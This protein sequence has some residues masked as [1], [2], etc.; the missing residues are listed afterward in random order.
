MIDLTEPWRIDIEH[1]DCVAA[2]RADKSDT[3]ICQ[4]SPSDDWEACAHLIAMAPALLAK[5]KN[6]V[7]W[8][9]RL[10]D[11]SRRQARDTRF[12]TMRE[13]CEAD[14]KNYKATADDIEKTIAQTVPEKKQ[15]KK[16]ARRTASDSL[17]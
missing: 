8:L 1:P 2:I 13:A 11:Q 3:E 4:I 16:R 14:A 9:R 12:E 7:A 17:L 5:C 6:I 15:S 10:E